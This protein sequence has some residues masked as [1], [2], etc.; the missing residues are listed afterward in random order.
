MKQIST[1]DRVESRNSLAN[2]TTTSSNPKKKRNKTRSERE[3][4]NAKRTSIKD[5]DDPTTKNTMKEIAR[6]FFAFAYNS[7]ETIN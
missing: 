2:K 3:V 7:T 4:S 5:D 1:I 6:F